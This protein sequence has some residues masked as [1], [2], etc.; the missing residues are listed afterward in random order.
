MF[1]EYYGDVFEFMIYV[2]EVWLMKIVFVL[3]FFRG[4]VFVRL[5]FFKDM[6]WI[7]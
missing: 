7:L 6:G 2:I 1:L 5:D 4:L 3:F